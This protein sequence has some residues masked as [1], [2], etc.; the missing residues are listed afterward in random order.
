MPFVFSPRS[1]RTSV[2]Q[3]VFDP[4]FTSTSSDPISGV[5][6][7]PTSSRPGPRNMAPIMP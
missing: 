3:T 1:M 4:T 2:P 5:S 6:I 7:S